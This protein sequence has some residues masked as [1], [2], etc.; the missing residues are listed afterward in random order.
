MFED[1]NV[2]IHLYL[3]TYYMISLTCINQT[4]KGILTLSYD[5][6]ELVLFSVESARFP[7]K[8]A[9]LCCVRVCAQYGRPKANH[10]GEGLSYCRLQDVVLT[11]AT[12]GVVNPV[13]TSQGRGGCDKI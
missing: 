5:I 8:Q 9:L 10:A 7:S 11:I 13:N 1:E 6:V 2:R 3:L 12:R 4:S